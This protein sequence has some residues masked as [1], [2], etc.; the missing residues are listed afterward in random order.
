MW[1]WTYKRR[2]SVILCL[3]LLLSI[4]ALGFA[5]KSEPDRDQSQTNPSN[6]LSEAERLRRHV[7]ETQIAPEKVYFWSP[8]S[9]DLPPGHSDSERDLH[10]L[11]RH[12]KPVDYKVRRGE[13]IDRIIRN[14]LFVS[15]SLQRRAYAIYFR[16]IKWR[17]KGLKP[18][19]IHPG[20]ILVL[21]NGP[22]YNALE[23]PIEREDVYLFRA[24]QLLGKNGKELSSEQLSRELYKAV[25]RFTL[26]FEEYERSPH[27]RPRIRRQ[28]LPEILARRILP[29]MGLDP[30]FERESVSIYDWAVLP[31]S[32]ES[33][34]SPGYLIEM[35]SAPEDCHSRCQTCS[36]ILRNPSIAPNT[37]DSRLLIVDT[38]I[39]PNAHPLDA[40]RF[41]A[42]APTPPA[43]APDYSDVS[44]IR[45]GT[46]IYTEVVNSYFGTL[47]PP[48]VLIARVAV[49]NPTATE[50]NA[51][52]LS[53]GDVWNSFVN[54]NESRKPSTAKAQ[55][56]HRPLPTW[57]VNLS[58]YGSAENKD[59]KYANVIADP[60]LLF[61][62][63]AGNN[64]T[65]INLESDLYTRFD[66]GNSNVL[67]VGALDGNGER[68]GYSN[69]HPDFVD[70]FAPGSCVCG[71]AK[72]FTSHD[73]DINHQINGTSQAAPVVAAAAKA[74]AEKFPAWQALEIKWR[75]I[76]TS[77]LRPDL[78]NMGKGGVLNFERA[79]DNDFRKSTLISKTFLKGTTTE[80][81][82]YVDPSSPVWSKLLQKNPAGYDVLRVHRLDSCSTRSNACFQVMRWISGVDPV[83]VTIPSNTSLPIIK[84]GK[85]GAITADQLR[86]L[87]QPIIRS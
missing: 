38:G 26:R 6:L 55:Q 7:L 48:D 24:R 9:D 79:I 70:I 77:D 47:D 12:A 39:E 11:L 86:D 3:A 42:P 8:R 13:N 80:S 40:E 76:S 45:H 37:H 59:I 83:T 23:A 78:V 29:A 36:T 30:S 69:H 46:F 41:Y 84:N 5:W 18:N 60:S 4:A 67:V 10:Y 25:G 61:V 52:T 73:P 32:L 50:P 87:I 34:S 16:N 14:Q 51:F 58:M 72:T 27:R 62:A 33:E 66:A 19:L 15:S 2:Y 81:I 63:A 44:D 56:E 28:A 17:N 53:M 49:P 22:K 54:L 31:S 75:L 20:D 64:G 82:D 1:R 35:R 85:K 71:D 74:I 68:A 57:I 21:P 43:K 65:H